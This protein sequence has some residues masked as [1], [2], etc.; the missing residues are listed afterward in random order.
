MSLVC[1]LESSNTK[2]RLKCWSV[3]DSKARL[4]KMQ[5]EKKKLPNI[6]KP[7]IAMITKQLQKELNNMMKQKFGKE[8]AFKEVLDV[9]LALIKLNIQHTACNH[10]SAE[11]SRGRTEE[12]QSRDKIGHG[13]VL[14][15]EITGYTSK[16]NS[17]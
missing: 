6:S 7:K 9:A 15:Y 12:Y 3:H 5:S 8:S 16:I 11:T 14:L 13:R 4:Y 2:T 17:G 1:E 10:Y